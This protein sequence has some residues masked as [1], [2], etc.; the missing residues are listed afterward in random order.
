[1]S[2][3]RAPAQRV[4]AWKRLGLK[5]KGAASGESPAFAPTGTGSTDSDANKSAPAHRHPNANA[6]VS[7]RLAQAHT[8]G[9][10]R[11]QPPT[12]SASASRHTESDLGPVKRL[13][14]DGPSSTPAEDEAGSRKSEKSVSF[15]EDTKGQEDGDSKSPKKTK[16]KAKKPKA[17]KPPKA[18]SVEIFSL[19]PSIAYLRQ[20]D[21]ARESWKFNKN[22]Q[23]LLIK[24]VFDQEKLPSADI[25]TFYKYIRDL[26]GFV[27]SRLREAAEEIKQKD[28]EQGAAAFAKST[29]DKEDKQKE[30][31]DVLSQLLQAQQ[32]GDNGTTNGTNANGKR[33]FD[34]VEFVLRTISPE[35]KQR[36]LKRMRAEM[37][38]DELS[39]SDESTTSTTTSSSTNTASSSAAAQETAEAAQGGKRVKLNDGSQKV[40]RRRLRNV[41]TENVGSDDSSSESDAES[42]SG[43][44]SSSSSEDESDDEEM[45]L[46]AGLNGDGA[47]SSSSSSSSDSS[48][49]ESDSDLESASGVE[50]GGDGE[51]SEDD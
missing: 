27:R 13:R 39:D 22:H 8:N 26:K 10:K 33:N 28:M 16:K 14:R 5:L 21:T 51:E 49:S 3:H 1:M 11:K 43:S 23:T 37:V 50:T 15:A 24:Y 12:A 7:G 25:G 47:S 41:R 46:A 48:G 19:E 45:P 38:L 18:G 34:E 4:P 2:T 40:K 29:Q 32:Q 30:Y 44:S 6:D 35:V 17:P 9:T 20:W 42:S 31:D 36:V